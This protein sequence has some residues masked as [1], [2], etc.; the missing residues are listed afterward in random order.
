MQI[1]TIKFTTSSGNE[2][3]NPNCDSDNDNANCKEMF[4]VNSLFQLRLLRDPKHNNIC[5]GY[6]TGLEL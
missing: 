6:V 5:T 2:F 4:T 1:G 3:Q